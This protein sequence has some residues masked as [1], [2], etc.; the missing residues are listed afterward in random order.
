MTGQTR[1]IAMRATTLTLLI[2]VSLSS[3]M[4]S[5]PARGETLPEAVAAAFATNPQLEIERYRTDIARSN[6]D[7]ARSSGL[8]QVNLSASG[9]YQSIDTNAAFAFGLGDQSLASTQ[10]QAVQPIYTGGRIRAGIRRAEAG[11]DSADRT[12]DAARQDLILDVVTAY[13]DVRRDRETVA[14][15]KNNVDVTGEQVRAAQDRFEGGVVT[16]TDVAQAQARL[17]GARAALA[18]A[19]AALEGSAAFYQFLTGQ[20]PGDLGEPPP[21]PPTIQ[22]PTVPPPPAAAPTPPPTTSR[23][24]LILA[25]IVLVFVVSSDPPIA[26]FTLFCCYA[27]SGY[28]YWGYNLMRGTPN[29]AKPVPAA[30]PQAVERSK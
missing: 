20:L 17:E 24:P 18:G 22:Q 1:K 10:L 3:L 6:L 29:P 23:L 9:G 13:V 27:L 25:I 8:P 30:V 2:G 26:L 7:L 15:R 16:R 4:F 5:A 28:V 14:I 21:F 19:E 12:F 11:I